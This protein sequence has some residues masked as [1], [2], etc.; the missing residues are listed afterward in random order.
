MEQFYVSVS[1][2]REAV[3]I[4]TDDKEHLKQAV[5]QSAERTS[6]TELMAKRQEQSQEINRISRFRQWQEKAVQSYDHLTAKFRNDGFQAA[7]R[8]E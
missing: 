8:T 3:S 4:Y 5:S 1:R 7:T 6:A 2:G